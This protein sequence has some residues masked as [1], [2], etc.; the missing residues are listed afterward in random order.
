ML[1]AGPKR[2]ITPEG[3]DCTC[4]KCYSGWYSP[5]MEFLIQ[6]KAHVCQ[7]KRVETDMN[8]MREKKEM[9]ANIISSG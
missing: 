9:S 8:A 5:R 4:G 3:A 6:S 2:L 1:Q 7:T